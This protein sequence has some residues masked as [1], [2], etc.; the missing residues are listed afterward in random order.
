M[1]NTI[2][3]GKYQWLEG[4]FCCFGATKTKKA[5]NT[6]KPPN[7][8]AFGGEVLTRLASLLAPVTNR[9]R[10]AES[11]GG[12][13]AALLLLCYR[14]WDPPFHT[15]WRSSGSSCRAIAGTA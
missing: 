13:T 10:C 14:R 11:R 2:P 4:F 8:C 5:P 9:Q 12:S 15:L 6:K 7:T 1:N 3:F